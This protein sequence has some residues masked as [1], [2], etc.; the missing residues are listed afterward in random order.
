MARECP[1]H[2][3]LPVGTPVHV[4]FDGEIYDEGES[5]TYPASKNHVA[6]TDG[7]FI[8]HIHRRSDKVAAQLPPKPD[9]ALGQVWRADNR[10]FVVYEQHPA[11]GDEH[12]VIHFWLCGVRNDMSRAEQVVYDD[13]AFANAFPE[14]RLL[15]LADGEVA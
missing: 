12:G 8:H 4:E 10:N 5:P 1:D 7:G 13:Q 11:F 14:A 15:L 6:V 3:A 9:M 2:K